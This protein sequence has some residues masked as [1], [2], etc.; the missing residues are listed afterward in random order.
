MR[1]ESVSTFRHALGIPDPPRP[2]CPDCLAPPKD[3]NFNQAVRL[4]TP[5]LPGVRYT[6]ITTRDDEVVTP[7]S[8][9]LLDGPPGTSVV[10]IV[11]QD[12]CELDHSDHLSIT[13]NRRSAALVL[14]ALDPDH[15]PP[16]P[17]V[18]VAPFIGG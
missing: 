13:S 4:P 12:S 17:C 6:N 8:S 3:T 14:G 16:V 2:E 15:A 7:Y 10:N 5:Y 18:P 1:G 9:G 11:V